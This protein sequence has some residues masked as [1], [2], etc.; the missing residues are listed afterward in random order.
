LWRRIT[1]AVWRTIIVVVIFLWFHPVSY[2]STRMAIVGL[3]LGIWSGALVLW[4]ERRTIRLVGLGLAVVVLALVA[5]PGRAY[6]VGQLRANYVKS[7]L[8]Y[9][10]TTYMWGGE[11]RFGIDCSGLVR[12]GLIDASLRQGVKSA[13]PGLIRQSFLMRWFDCSASALQDEYRMQTHRLFPARSIHDLDHSKLKAGDFAVTS[14]GVHTLAYLGDEI[15]IQADPGAGRVIKV[16]AAEDN[17]WLH[18]PIQVMR[19]RA[20]E[21]GN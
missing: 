7:L 14:S 8:A 5:W 12:R 17:G 16:R 2:R 18:M 20:F 3:L 21:T 10:G 4:W 1:L 13:N 6:D 11:N 9:E 15:W 19:W